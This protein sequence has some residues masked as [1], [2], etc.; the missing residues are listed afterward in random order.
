MDSRVGARQ[1]VTSGRVQHRPAEET[2]HPS[3]RTPGGKFA[4]LSPAISPG[5]QVAV[6]GY[7]FQALPAPGGEVAPLAPD[8]AGRSRA[9]GQE[10]GAEIGDRG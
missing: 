6:G 8:Q 7:T 10:P 3:L 2:L 5:L 1:A 4:E 9:H